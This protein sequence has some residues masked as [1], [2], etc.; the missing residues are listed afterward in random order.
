MNFKISLI[1]PFKPFFFYMT[2]KSRQKFTY[3]ENEKS[4]YDVIKSIFHHFLR[5]IIDA[6]IFLEGESPTL[7]LHNSTICNLLSYL[8]LILLQHGD[9]K[10]N[11]GPDKTK[12]KNFSCCHWNVNSLVGHN[13][14]N[15]CQLKHIIHYI[16]TISIVYLKPILTPLI[17]ITMKTY[18]QMGTV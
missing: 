17:C 18:S 4:F 16:T 2:K 15:L 5:A 12:L 13:F 11:P 6:N 3:L 7:N 9:I 14:S 1:F 8:H 10:S